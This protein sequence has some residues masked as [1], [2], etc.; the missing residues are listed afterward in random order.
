AGLVDMLDVWGLSTTQAESSQEVLSQI[1]R[2]RDVGRPFDVLFLGIDLIGMDGLRLVERLRKADGFTGSIAM[3]MRCRARRGDRQRCTEL[4]VDAVVTRPFSQSEVLD[5]LALALARPV[6]AG[7]PLQ[8][9]RP[10]TILLADD[11]A[12]NREVAI[13]FLAG[14]GHSVT[15]VQDGVE[16]LATLERQRFDVAILD[17]HMPGADG[18]QV[19]KEIRRRE[20]STRQRLVIIAMTAHAMPGD[21][22]QCLA[23]GMDGYV[24]KPVQAEKLFQ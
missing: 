17:V 21:R 18:F 9:R 19:T 13:A 11:N 15:P 14:W 3:A 10:L 16:A 7:P 22:E 4:G 8:P 2:A 24:A 20:A 1:A 23:A 12:V 6:T 5:A